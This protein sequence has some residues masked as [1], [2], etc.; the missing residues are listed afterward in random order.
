MILTKSGIYQNP[1]SPFLY[2][3]SDSHGSV[4]WRDDT[5]Y[6]VCFTFMHDT[7]HVSCYMPPEVITPL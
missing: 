1:V 2:P 3:F 5:F 4:P 6:P 7:V